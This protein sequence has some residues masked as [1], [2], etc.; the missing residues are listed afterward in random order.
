MPASNESLIQS[1][2]D[3]LYICLYMFIFRNRYLN[4]SINICDFISDTVQYM[5]CY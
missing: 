5:T 3:A 1:F 4:S 2:K